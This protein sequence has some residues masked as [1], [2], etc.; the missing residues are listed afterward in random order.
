MLMCIQI[1]VK[2]CPLVFK[3]LSI[4]ENYDGMTELQKDRQGKSS[5]APTF[6]KR[7]YNKHSFDFYF[8]LRVLGDSPDFCQ[9]V[10]DSILESETPNPAS[11]KTLQPLDLKSIISS[12]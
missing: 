4:N 11:G 12:F 9:G 10:P 6:S 7:G 5:I 1:L 8:I 3:I 2:F